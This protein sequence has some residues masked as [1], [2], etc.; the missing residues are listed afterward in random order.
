MT[1]KPKPSSFNNSLFERMREMNRS[2]LESLREIHQIE[3]IFESRLLAARSQAEAADICGEWM[4]QRL[5]A[6]AVEQRRFT[7]AWLEVVSDVMKSASP[8]ANGLECSMED[9]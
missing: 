4:K 2:W 7:A 8:A 1:E 5:D 9:P 3:L 6:V